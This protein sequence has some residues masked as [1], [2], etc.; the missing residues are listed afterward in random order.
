MPTKDTEFVHLH[1]HTDHSLLDGCS[2]TDRLCQRAAEMGMK[3]LSITD[4]GVLYGLTSFFKQAEKHGIKPLLGCEIYL[5]YEEELATTNEERAKQKSRHMGLLARNFKGYQNLCKIVSK[6][7]TQGFYRNPRTDLKTLVEHS[8]GLIGFSGC[9]AAVIPQFLLEGEYEK[10]RDACAKFVDIFG[11][12]FFIIEIMDHGI[13][14][15]RRIIPD[16]IKLATEFDLKIV[17]TN[18]V[19]YVNNSDWEPHDSLLCI[20]TGAKVRDE[21]RMRYDAQQFYL[22]SRD[23]MELAFKEVPESIINTSA[24][25]EMCEVKLPFGEDHYPVYERPIELS[26]N[27]DEANFDRVLDIYVEKKNALLAR[28]GKEP[29]ELTDGERIK[30]KSNGLYLFELCKQGLKDRYGTDYDACRADWENASE[31]DKRYCEQMEYELAIITGTG[32]VDYFLIVWDFINWARQQGIPV[33]PGR[34]SG[35]GCIVAYVLKITDI[36]PLSF[37]LLFERMLNLERVSPPDFDVDFCMRRRDEVVNYVRDKYGKDRVANII[38]FGTF[39]A[40][41]IVRDLARVND[42]EFAEANKLAKMIPDELNIT[43]ED[44]V[45]KSPE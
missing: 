19:H 2:R 16:L 34:G 24:V 12:K 9:L 11:K 35:A 43:L 21:K 23:E 31:T 41:M 30:H 14:E 45:K 27:K 33:G 29:I 10:A 13:E 6:A 22:K 4:H 38:T 8:E 39:G 20:Q 28:D 3:A 32:F 25:A 26:F 1:V 15:Q 7:H 36:D 40:K 17:A 5:V 37:G 18:D 44:S 42:I